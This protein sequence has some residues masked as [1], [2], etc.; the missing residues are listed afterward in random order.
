[1][2]KRNTKIVLVLWI[3]VIF[4]FIGIFVFSKK[5]NGHVD[6]NCVDHNQ[7]CGKSKDYLDGFVD[8]QDYQNIIWTNHWP[9]TLPTADI[10]TNCQGP[11]CPWYKN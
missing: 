3:I 11:S 8:G 10:T 6:W 7:W 9:N 4:I 2:N 1:M 5:E